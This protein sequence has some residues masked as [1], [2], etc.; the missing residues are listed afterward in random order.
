[1]KH[2]VEMHLEGTGPALDEFV[3]SLFVQS[4]P[5]ARIDAI[6]VQAVQP[7]GFK[8]FTIRDSRLRGRPSV[9]ISPDLPVCDSCLDELFDPAN[10]RYHYPYI[11]C[12]NCGPRYSVIL[13]LPYDRLNT[14][15]QEWPLDGFCAGSTTI[16]RTDVSM[17]SPSRARRVDRTTFC[18]R[19]T[20]S[21]S[22]TT[23]ASA[24]PS[25]C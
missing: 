11:N 24:E 5:A 23:Q 7:T 1:M 3:R 21:S 6:D 16:P 25:S 9:R 14:T 18:E 19:G 10:P 17:R 8:E 4:P 20:K 15:M 13:S 2:G 12:T 22:A